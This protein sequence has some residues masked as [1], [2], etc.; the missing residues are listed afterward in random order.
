MILPIVTTPNSI[1]TKPTARITEVTPE[2]RQLVE[3]MRETMHNAQGLGLAAPQV[4]QS[5]SLCI[6]EFKDEDGLE[7]IPFMALVNPRVT[8]KS[9]RT[10]TDEEA[11]LSIPYVGGMVKRPREVR[12]KAEDLDGNPIEIEARGLLARALQHEI[13]H[14]NGILFTSYVSKSKL[15]ERKTPDYP[16]I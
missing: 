5:I 4:G 8:W 3:D 13:D 9:A 12:V 14:L 1:L 2:I 6:L 15:L 10:D 16:R 11:C 7:D